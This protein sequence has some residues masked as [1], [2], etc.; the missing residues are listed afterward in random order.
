MDD[1]ILVINSGSSSLKF[2]I[3]AQAGNQLVVEG[4]AEGLG[5][6][7]G[8]L[9]IKCDGRKTVQELTQADHKNALVKINS[10]L[11]E[12]PSLKSCLKGIGHRIVHGGE[13]FSASVIIDDNVIKHLNECAELAP[14]HSPAHLKGIEIA[15]Y[16]FPTL[17]QVAVFDTAFHQ[18]IEKEHFLYGIPISYYQDYHFRKYGFH[19]TSYRYISQKLEECFPL[20]IQQGVLV[21]HLGNGASVCAINSGKSSDTSMGLTPLDG[22]MMGTRSGSVDPSLIAFI[23]EKEKLTVEETIDVLNKKSGLL[24]VS[25]I[26]NDCRLLEEAMQAGNVK[27]KL[28]L[29]MFSNRA[30]KQLMSVATTLNSIDH[31]VFTGGIG[32]NSTY[33]REKICTNLKA[34]NISIDTQKNLNASRGDISSIAQDSSSS[35]IWIIPTN[36]EKMIALDTINLIKNDE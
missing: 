13:F 33:I 19:G 28:A 6:S 7:A 26:S 4:I 35:K 34:F 17:P 30:A 12:S 14:L 9:T 27:A 2:A 29:D 31:I 5:S 24:G 8:H 20:S 3:L 15:Q 23:A 11:E 1:A 10:W 18:T 36:E 16:L 21:A 22:L 25:E 32:E